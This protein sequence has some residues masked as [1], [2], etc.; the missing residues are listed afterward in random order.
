[1]LAVVIGL[2]PDVIGLHVS[3]FGCHNSHLHHLLLW[4]N[5]EW[6]DTVVP[7]YSDCPGNGC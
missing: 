7:A 5:P 4:Q 1:M 3:E 2:K 6:F